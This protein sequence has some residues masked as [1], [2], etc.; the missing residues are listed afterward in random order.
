ML[1]TIIHR[2]FLYDVIWVFSLMNIL[3]VVMQSYSLTYFKNYNIEVHFNP[4]WGI[5]ESIG[6]CLPPIPPQERTKGALRCVHHECWKPTAFRVWVSGRQPTPQK[7]QWRHPRIFLEKKFI[8]TSS[9]S[10]L[11][12][13]SY[14][15]NC[16]SR[17]F[18]VL[19]CNIL[20]APSLE[21]E[22][23]LY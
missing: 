22:E 3:S 1:C 16:F 17:S 20:Q 23:I 13:S 19:H 14:I 6:E 7:M 8:L 10:G 12:Q 21:W 15:G 5:G 9:Y 4:L 18:Q 11:C 2:Y